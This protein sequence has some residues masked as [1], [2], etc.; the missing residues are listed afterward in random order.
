MYV[1]LAGKGIA[2][3][4]IDLAMEEC[5]AGEDELEAIRRLA[6]KRKYR[7]QDATREEQQ[8]QMAYFM[9]KGF[10]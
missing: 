2:R 8:K 5:Y 1:Q 9:R 4:L 10:L 6:V 7:F 3:E